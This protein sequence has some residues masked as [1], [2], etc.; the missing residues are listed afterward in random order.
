MKNIFS[1]LITTILISTVLSC[2]SGDGMNVQSIPSLISE[3]F[4]S[5][6]TYE[7]VCRGFPKQG[8]TGVQ[9][10]E[11]AKRAA[12]LNAYYFVQSRFDDTVKP[13]TDGI[14]VKYD[15]QDE[16]VIVYYRVTKS[17]LKKREKQK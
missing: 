12:L 1:I 9:K 3:E 2:S 17:N 16:Y 7:V 5:N 15:V 10:E 4:T 13:D 6:E 14:V 11:S 8:L